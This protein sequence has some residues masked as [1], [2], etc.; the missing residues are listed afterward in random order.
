[1]IDK[2]ERERVLKAGPYVHGGLLPAP[3]AAVRWGLPAAYYV[4]ESWGR[5]SLMSL[6]STC[7]C[8]CVRGWV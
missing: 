6:V 3:E 7:V 4:C 8:V 2:R 1:M 5:L